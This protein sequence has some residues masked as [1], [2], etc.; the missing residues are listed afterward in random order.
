MG[1][2]ASDPRS[3]YAAWAERADGLGH[4]PDSAARHGP[5]MRPFPLSRP[6]NPKGASVTTTA[7]PPVRP[8]AV[9]PR[10][11]PATSMSG[12]MP[13]TGS[14]SRLRRRGRPRCLLRSAALLEGPDQHVNTQVFGPGAGSSPLA[15]SLGRS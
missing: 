11:P 3:F 8:L 5:G 1:A 6:A 14:A 2:G 9:S 15:R 10:W 12:T 4:P 7:S 13:S